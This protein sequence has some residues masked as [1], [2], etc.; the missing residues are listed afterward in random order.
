MTRPK[1]IPLQLA[2]LVAVPPVGDRWAFEMKYDGYRLEAQIAKGRVTLLTRRGNDWTARFPRIADRLERLKVRSTILDGELVALD[3]SGKS[4]FNLLQQSLEADASDDLI[5]FAFDLIEL[6]G[7]DLRSSPLDERRRR[8]EKLLRSERATDRGV[9]RLGQRLDGTGAALIRA[10]CGLGLEG[11]IGKLRDAPYTSGRGPAWVKIKCG[12]RQEFVIVGF[13][14]PRGSRVGIGSLLLAVHERSGLRYAGRVGS[15]FADDALRGLL[16]RL[17]RLE[18]RSSPLPTRPAGIPDGTRWVGPSLVAEVSFTEWTPD[19]L[20]RHPVFQGLRADKPAGEVRREEPKMNRK[21]ATPAAAPA[22][23]ATSRTA[24]TDMITHPDRVVYPESGITK[25]EL[26]QYFERFAPLMLPHV[27]GRPLS[28]VRCPEGSAHQCFF[29]KHWVGRRPASIATVPIRQSDG[30]KHPHVVIHDAAGLVT[31]V[32]W[33]VME[34]HPWGARADDPEHPDRI[35]F[36]LDPDPGVPWDRVREATR[37]LHAL[38]DALGLESWVKTSGGK[39]LHVVVPIARRSGWDEASGFA[40]AVAERMQAEF[41][42]RFISKAS[43]AARKGLIFV[44]WLRNTRGATAVA[45]WSTR[46]RPSAGV[47]VPIRWAELDDLKSGDQ[48]TLDTMRNAPRR[49]DP[50]KRLLGSRQSITAAIMRK[51]A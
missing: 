37:G 30:K 33:G 50:W 21:S 23:K 48:F 32:Q 34:I 43:K 31:L 1:F 41:P 29:Q 5:F 51:L 24:L 7:V 45:P 39:G 40:R 17:E 13:T 15:G 28:L 26:A 2:T 10:A 36:D 11:I 46:A 12:H 16:A 8:L 22:R 4:R 6:D 18:R 19:G 44:D 35:T 49:V 9:L 27:A 38:L 3:P 14:P 47:S 42:D 20:L 25:L